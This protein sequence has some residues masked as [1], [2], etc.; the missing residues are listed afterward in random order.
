MKTAVLA[1]A[2]LLCNGIAFAA[3]PPPRPATVIVVMPPPDNRPLSEEAISYS[4]ANEGRKAAVRAAS[5]YR[6]P[7]A[8]DTCPPPFRMSER[9]GCR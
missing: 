1:A 3:D 7:G 6:D 4:S 9:D 5:G 8:R 2:L